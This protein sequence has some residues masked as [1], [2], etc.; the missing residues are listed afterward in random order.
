[1]VV[2]TWGEWKAIGVTEVWIV[3]SGDWFPPVKS[4]DGTQSVGETFQVVTGQQL[5][6]VVQV[7]FS[8][9]ILVQVSFNTAEPEWI[10]SVEIVVVGG[11]TNIFGELGDTMFSVGEVLITGVVGWNGNGVDTIDLVDVVETSLDVLLGTLNHFGV[12]EILWEDFVD[13]W[14]FESLQVFTVDEGNS[15]SVNELLFVDVETSPDQCLVECIPILGV[16]EYVEESDGLLTVLSVE[17]GEDF[18]LGKET[19]LPQLPELLNGLDVG[20]MVPV[21]LESPFG[22]DLVEV[23]LEVGLCNVLQNLQQVSLLLKSSLISVY[24]S[25]TSGYIASC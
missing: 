13:S 16:V 12:E 25:F 4:W 23:C 6:V 9:T 1:M 18:V 2:V 3:A 7:E 10:I 5:L 24:W 20:E 17:E 14:K 22:S 15:Q 8:A 19:V 21:V 11:Q